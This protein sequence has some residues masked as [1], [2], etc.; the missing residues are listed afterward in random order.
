[1]FQLE[2]AV[3]YLRRHE[4]VVNHMY[5]DVV[6]LVTIGVGFLL[7]DAAA[8]QALNLVRRDGGNPASVDEK[9]ADWEAVHSRPKAE[10]A[11]NYRAF[12]RLDLPDTAIDAELADLITGFV[13]NLES[14]F[15][16]FQNYPAPAQTG[17]IDMVYSLGPAGLFRGFPKF[18]AAVDQQDWAACAQEGIRGNVSQSRNEELQGLFVEAAAAKAA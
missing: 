13:R 15:P 2:E 5:L 14:R 1:M 3:A 12:T 18:C 8:A 11:A 16:Q 6:G 10:L 4:G 17:L 7:P 9:A